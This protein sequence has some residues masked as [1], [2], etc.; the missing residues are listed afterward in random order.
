MSLVAKGRVHQ[1]VINQG[2]SERDGIDTMSSG[3]MSPDLGEM[4][5]QGYPVSPQWEGELELDSASDY[6]NVNEEVDSSVTHD[7]ATESGPKDYT[8]A[9]RK[10]SLWILIR[11]SI[12][13][14]DVLVL[15]TAGSKW[16]NAKLYG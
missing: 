5:R 4:W 15:R 11:D 16:N 7:H 14:P 10:C 12:S 13:P 1:L 2:C 6:D 8:S 9:V 3:S